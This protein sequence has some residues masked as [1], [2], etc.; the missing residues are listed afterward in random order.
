MR[1]KPVR[2]L[3]LVCSAV[4]RPAGKTTSNPVAGKVPSCQLRLSDQLSLSLGLPVSPPVHVA[5]GTATAVRTTELPLV[6]P[7]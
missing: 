2:S 4:L 1:L 5:E 6:P 7:T 3:L